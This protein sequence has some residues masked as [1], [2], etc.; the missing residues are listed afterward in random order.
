MSKIRNWFR[1]LIFPEI[2]LLEFRI[3]GQEIEL[4]AL[5]DAM[6]ENRLMAFV[7]IVDYERGVPIN[8]ESPFPKPIKLDDLQSRIEKLETPNE[9]A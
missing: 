2:D 6:E 5:K 9:Q 8:Y 4:Q 1:R 7:R 3:E